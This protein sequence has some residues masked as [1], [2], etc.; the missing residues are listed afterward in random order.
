M[1]LVTLAD[2]L[3]VMEPGKLHAWAAQCDDPSKLALVEE[4]MGDITGEGWRTDPA[5]MAAHLDPSYRTPPFIRYLSKKFRDGIEGISNRQIWNVPGRYGK[6]LLTQKG[7]VWGL[8]RSEGHARFIDTSYGQ[9]LANE[10][11]DGVREMLREHSDVLRC[12]L[13]RDRQSLRRFVTDHGGGLLAVGMAATITGFGVNKGGALIVDDPFKNWE[14]A[15]SEFQRDKKFNQFRGTLRNRL[16]DED[17]FILVV[18]HRVHEDDLTARLLAAMQEDDEYG[19]KWDVTVLPAI[20]VAGDVIG[21]APGEPLDPEVRPLRACL[22]RAAGMGSYLASSLEQQDPNPEEGN[23]I[24]RAWWRFDENF[25]PAFDDSLSSWDTKMKDKEAGDY[26]VGQVWGRT[27]SDFWCVAEVR[28]QWN[29]A[30]TRAAIALIAVRYPW[31]TRHLVEFAGLGPE[32]IEDLT[33]GSGP[34]YILDP[35]MASQLGMTESE[36]E[37][38]QD[39][40]RAGLPGVIGQPVKGD[41]RVRARAVS[42]FIEAGNCHLPV[43]AMWTSGF[44]EEVSAFPNGKYDDRV[45]AM[46][47]ALAKLRVGGAELVEADVLV[48]TRIPGVGPAGARIPSMGSRFD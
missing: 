25:P 22:S 19:D 23:D 12:Q 27:G 43:N 7:I 47:Q 13:R 30:Q 15:H 34:D 11:A 37:A 38:V 31:V 14:E 3:R 18:M 42:P 45:D 2:Q 9:M 26:V 16:D 29:Q 35:D 10:N 5:A 48:D 39:M 28:G 6:S 4:V 36:R 44:L 8:D 41:K 20:A 24:K 17:A 21:R 40:L 32:V 1:S 46:S 33:A